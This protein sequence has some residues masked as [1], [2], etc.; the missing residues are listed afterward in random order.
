MTTE[1]A[2]PQSRQ[3]NPQES[4]AVLIGASTYERLDSLPAVEKNLEA[5]RELLMDASIWGLPAS[6]CEVLHNP[7]SPT[8]VVRAVH[9]AASVATD[10]LLVYFAGHG[11]PEGEADLHLALPAADNEH[12]HE[13]V[14]YD[15]IRSVIV[16]TAKR[17][18]GKVVIL[19][20][21]YSGRA[22]TGVM[23]AD[24]TRIADQARIDGTYLM[25]ATA[26][27]RLALAPPGAQHTAFTGA[28]IDKLTH[29]IAGGPDLLDMETLFYHVRAD[30]AARNLPAPQQRSRND[31]KAIALARN[32]HTSPVVVTPPPPPR[33]QLSAKLEP[34]VM[35]KP[36]EVCDTVRG[37]DESQR[38]AFF[39]AL[40]AR[41]S[42]QQLATII[43]MLPE[44]TDLMRA[45]ARLAPNE[46]AAIH[47]TLKL[48]GLPD[49]A[50]RL[51]DVAAEDRASNVAELARALQHDRSYLLDAAAERADTRAEMVTLVSSLW[52]VGLV[53][54]VDQTLER[55]T[56]RLPPQEV[57]LLAD[58]MRA[59]G[60]ERIAYLLYATVPWVMSSRPPNELARLIAVMRNAGH[61]RWAETLASGLLGA[62]STL[63]GISALNAND[64]YDTVELAIEHAARALDLAEII[65]LSE[66]LHAERLEEISLRL[67]QRAAVAEPRSRGPVLVEALREDGR[68][69]D[70]R[71]VVEYLALHAPIGDLAVM[72]D[73]IEPADVET[74]LRTLG[75]AYDERAQLRSVLTAATTEQSFLVLLSQ[76]DVSDSLLDAAVR[77]CDPRSVP[78]AMKELS[79]SAA[80]RLFRAAV[81]SD[82]FPRIFE[83]LQRT[84]EF[85]A[86]IR[87]VVWLGKPDFK[88]VYD[89]SVLDTALR[90]QGH[91]LEAQHIVDAAM[92]SLDPRFVAEFN[93]NLR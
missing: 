15:A 75:A 83:A 92:D 60:H 78:R 4:R 85:D 26:E 6:H 67:C 70:A 38:P 40:V 12:I 66:Q 17:C 89:L 65:R 13:A 55:M 81:R 23:S 84:G 41:R 18:Y 29:G 5:L 50:R 86:E 53:D 57:A 61:D 93:A 52:L 31:G 33:P 90:R 51:L 27:N 35:G 48:I 87:R 30:L 76:A 43:G 72:V 44:A 16:N 47:Q 10:V 46:V 71:R 58:D 68:P 73:A 82:K 88:K 11:L 25:T 62:F 7:G 42:H 80:S 39:E 37:L 63:A 59:A 77:R 1:G 24:A 3:P 14:R 54:V 2:G 64:L 36:K 20:C 45:V 49:G 21:C 34:L 9:Q 79:P 69:L 8:H 91:T 74:L 32:R 56:H 22:L 28:L 19:D